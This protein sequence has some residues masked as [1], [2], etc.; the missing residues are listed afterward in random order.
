MHASLCLRLTLGPLAALGLGLL[1][2]Q[3]APQAQTLAEPAVHR[4]SAPEQLFEVV[5][6]VDGDTLHILRDGVKEK[7]RLLSVDTEE[8]LSG[9]PNPSPTKPETVFGE[10]SAAWAE[11]WLPEHATVDGRVQVG[12]AFPGGNEQRDI[13]GRL[14]CHVLLPDGT[15]FNVELVR[16]GKSPYFNKYG[17]SLICQEAFLNAQSGAM[18]QSLGIWNPATNRPANSSAPAVVRP[19]E[20][21]LPWWQ[22]RADA[23][24]AFRQRAAKNPI[25]DV[26]ADDPTGLELAA[27]ACDAGARVSV[28][29]SIQRIFVEDDG[30]WTLLMRSGDSGRSV[31]GRIQAEDLE[32]F[33]TADL[34][35]RATEEFCQNY[36]ILEGALDRGSRGFEIDLL[37]PEQ[38]RPAGPEPRA[39]LDSPQD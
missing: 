16:L 5:K 4:H 10:E 14:L 9:N 28:F 1:F 11:S 6:I 3:T 21:L 19:Y 8:K 35:R 31:R 23:V 20:R 27:F 37:G 26:A 32:Q 18:E 34:K 33:D 13:Y 25:R 38:V 2:A 15:D 36:L 7:L 22:A 39:P 17:E 30:D 29:G 12:L 24:T